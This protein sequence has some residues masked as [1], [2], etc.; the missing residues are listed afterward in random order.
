M[1]RLGIL[2]LSLA[3]FAACKQTPSTGN[4]G[5][6]ITPDGAVS[7]ADFMTQLGDKPEMEGKIIATV[8]QVC[9]SEGCWYTVQTP[10]G[11]EMMIMTK[12]HSFT[13]PKDCAGKT[14]IAEGRAYWKETSVDD[15]KHYAADAGK[16]PEEI[17][18][19]TEP[20]RELRFEANGVIIQGG[21]EAGH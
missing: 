3:V 14:A 6:N 7:V 13:L 16:S 5:A 8:N 12:D 18:A 10:S 17:A 2:A 15:L 20:K 1:K 19:I 21:E 4:F 9:Q 11:D